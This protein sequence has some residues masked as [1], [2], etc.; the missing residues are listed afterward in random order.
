MCLGNIS[1]DL[2]GNS[3]KK[4]TGLNGYVSKFYIDCNIINILEYLM[5]N[6]DIKYC[7]V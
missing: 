7:L 4:K 1:K 5:K 6:Y 3:I 2:T